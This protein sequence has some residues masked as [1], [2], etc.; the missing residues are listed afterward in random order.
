MGDIF[1]NYRRSDTQGEAGRL[2]DDVVEEFGED[3][4][5]MDV[6]GIEPGRDFRQAIKERLA[7]CDT[8]LVVIGLEWLDAK[9]AHGKRRLDDPEDYVRIEISIAL[10][11]NIRVIPV[12]VRGANMP[13]AERLPEDLKDLA[14]RN[15]F[16]ITHSKWKSDVRL[17]IEALHRARGDTPQTG[18]SAA[19]SLQ[20]SKERS[21]PQANKYALYAVL[22]LLF[23]KIILPYFSGG[24]PERFKDAL[25]T[26]VLLI[27]VVS[28]VLP[29]K[30]PRGPGG[31]RLPS[32]RLEPSFM[33]GWYGGIVGGAIAGIVVGF[34]YYLSVRQ[35]YPVAGRSAIAPVFGWA[36]LAGF[37]L[38][39]TSQLGAQFARFLSTASI[40]PVF[41]ANEVVGGALGAAVGGVFVG[42]YGGWIFGPLP[43]PVVDPAL[44]CMGGVIGALAVCAGA[45]LYNYR[46]RL[47]DVARVFFFSSIP[48]LVAAAV[49]FYLI[50]AGNIG[51]RF[52]AFTATRFTNLK[53]GAYMGAIVGSALGVQIGCTLLLY[54]LTN[55]QEESHL[56]PT[57]GP[58]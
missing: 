24:K 21:T 43:L 7:K 6:V 49:G 52:F 40:A 11:S 56:A 57:S 13:S 33:S 16:E 10:K 36:T 20:S 22:G 35:K 2:F 28:Q 29:R 12:L 53:G 31:S 32:F 46:G 34:T 15:C 17:L 54:R 58:P 30:N 14:Y 8:L 25:E 23:V 47:K 37:F 48:T 41:I 1:L 45:L 3:T 39:A 42:A 50:L 4:V 5:F 44:L 9:D 26:S 18:A 27:T 51:P 38:G 19:S 55:K